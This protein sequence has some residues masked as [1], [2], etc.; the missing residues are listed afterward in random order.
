MTSKVDSVLHL[1]N[2]RK[3]VTVTGPISDWQNDEVAAVFSVVISQASGNGAG[4]TT[5]IGA[6][7]I[8]Y[9][10]NEGTWTAQAK[11]TGSNMQFHEGNA[12]AHAWATIAQPGGDAESYVWTV[13]TTLSKN[14]G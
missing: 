4:A 11:V 12:T 1:S 9:V 2:D 6:S 5:A 13:P 14:G 7:T 3:T 8:T 10:P